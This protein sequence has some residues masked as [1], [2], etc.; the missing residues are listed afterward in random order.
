MDDVGEAINWTPVQRPCRR[1]LAGATVRLDPIDP[2]TQRHALY[3]A[4]HDSRD[5]ELWKYLP[6]GPLPDEDSFTAWLVTA[7][8]SEDPLFFAVVDQ[9]TDRP[10]GMVSFMRMAPEHGVIEIG[11]I[12]FGPA[13][14]RTRQAT[15]AIYL[16]ARHT[17]DDLSYRR[18]EWKCNALNQRSRRAALRF[19]FSYEGIFRQHMVV[20]GRN[21]DT[22][23]YSIVDREW[24]DIR[25]AFETWLQPEN[26]D[27]GGNQRQ[28][29]S[30]I[31]EQILR[32]PNMPT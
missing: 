17:F 21:R 8:R 32:N 27:T 1:V 12:W 6:V 11:F 24:P 29:L 31:R 26:F 4:S 22:A 5:S 25:G 16:L 23:W 30:A 3:E 14:Q 15:E 19:G 28:S 7:A 20:K 18:L 9:E 2:K 13:L 10:S